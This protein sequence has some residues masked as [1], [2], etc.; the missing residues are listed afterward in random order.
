M[1]LTHEPMQEKRLMAR[2]AAAGRLRPTARS[3]VA[4]LRHFLTPAA[5]KQANRARGPRRQPR[6]ATQPLVLVLLALTW[7]CGDST[8]ERFETAKAFVAVCLPKRR[9]PGRTVSGFQKALARLP[10]F[11]PRILRLELDPVTG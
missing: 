5:W 11:A 6:W 3:L 10:D 1:G 2:S 9:R 7:A 4:S 8:P